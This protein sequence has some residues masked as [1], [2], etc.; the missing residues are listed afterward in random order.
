MLDWLDSHADVPRGPY[1]SREDKL[2]IAQK[3]SDEGEPIC[4]CQAH[5]AQLSLQPMSCNPHPHPHTHG[6][7]L[8]ARLF[9]HEPPRAGHHVVQQQA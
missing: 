9:I 8:P 7:E 5:L 3:T 1:P 4:L 2:R 6:S